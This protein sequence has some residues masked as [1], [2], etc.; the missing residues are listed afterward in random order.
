MIPAVIEFNILI[1]LNLGKSFAS[2]K[3][4][5]LFSQPSVVNDILYRFQ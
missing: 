4:Q 2:D 3:G 1:S 5:I